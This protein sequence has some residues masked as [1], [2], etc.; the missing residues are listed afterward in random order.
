M[1]RE[2]I[3]L[4]P[5]HR[6]SDDLW[7]SVGVCID[8]VSLRDR[9]GRKMED[10]I[11]CARVPLDP[12]LPLLTCPSMPPPRPLPTPAASVPPLEV[13]GYP[14]GMCMWSLAIC[15]SGCILH[16]DALSDGTFT[17]LAEGSPRMGA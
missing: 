8:A 15:A 9:E 6:P 1:V 10:K 2:N 11:Q 14:S 12:P 7:V 4:L 16:I 3:F 13:T 5:L 17:L